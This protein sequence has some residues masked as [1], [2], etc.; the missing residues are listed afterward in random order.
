[1]QRSAGAFCAAEVIIHIWPRAVAGIVPKWGVGTNCRSVERSA[2]MSEKRGR[3]E[4]CN[5]L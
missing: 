5:L 3:D 4:S 1:M 2:P